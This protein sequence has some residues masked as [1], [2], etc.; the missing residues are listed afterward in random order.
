MTATI[1]VAD[2]EKGIRRAME[3]ALRDDPRYSVVAEALETARREK[4]ALIFLDVRMPRMSGLE[5]CRA[6]KSDPAT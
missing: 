3:A 5:V 6:L 1:M 4:P 2:D